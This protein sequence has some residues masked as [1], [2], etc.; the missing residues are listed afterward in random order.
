VAL[1]FAGL[2]LEGPAAAAWRRKG[3]QILRRE[4]PEQ[5]LA[6]GGHYERS[7]LYHGVMLEDLLDLIVLAEA[8]GDLVPAADLA[9]LRDRATAAT[10]FFAELLYPDGDIPLFNDAAFGIA[11]AP[12]RLLAYA[13]RV[14]RLDAGETAPADGAIC[15][16]ASGYYG[17]RQGGDLL[18][19]DCGPLGPDYQPGHGH[20]DLLSYE[21][22]YD[23][24]RVVVDSG[25]FG[26]EVGELRS[27]CRSTAAHNSV[28]IDGEEQSEIWHAFRVGR[29]AR[30]LEARQESGPTEPYVFT[31]AHDGYRRL[32]G[33]PV[34]E[35]QL[36]FHRDGMLEVEDR[37][38]GKEQHRLE[39]FLHIHPDFDVVP[40]DNG[41]VLRPKGGGPAARLQVE[42]DCRAALESGQ[43]CPI[44]GL[45][46]ENPVIVLRHQ[47]SLPAILR[48]RIEKYPD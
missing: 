36:R 44:F 34:H 25:V 24:R 33:G 4:I 2:L 12:A 35:R 41:F 37:V 29:R 31:G 19:I 11:P 16:A 9:Q 26:Y 1:V 23:G 27:Y 14:L 46:L 47:G 18:L 6:D 3:L 15:A 20:C 42:S 43:F 45:A 8:A 17:A 48:Y 40:E 10:R 28:R 22:C 32:P 21:L 13:A 5:F 39:S 7:L 30:V 38:R